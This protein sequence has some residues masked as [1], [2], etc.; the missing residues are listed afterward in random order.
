M[1]ERECFVNEPHYYAALLH[2]LAHWTGAKALLNRDI[3]QP[4][5]SEAH[6]R[7]EIRADLT[8]LFLAAELGVPFDPKDQAG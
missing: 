7:E 8:S 6:S 2:E 3:E 1:P 4:F 5:S